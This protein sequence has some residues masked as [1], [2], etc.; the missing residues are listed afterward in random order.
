MRRY[1]VLLLAAAS[2]AAQPNQ[3]RIL[4]AYHSESGN[5][6]KIAMA[7]RDGAAK[8]E[9]VTVTSRKV[10]AVVD[11]DIAKAD[12]IVV[13]TPVHW[14]NLSTET[15]RL[16]DRIG[17]VIS[18]SKSLGDGRAAGAFCTGG[19]VAMG[20][21]LA[22]ISILSAFLTMRFAVIGGVDPYG[23]GTLGPQATTGPD[24]AGISDKE[25]DEARQYGE[26]FAR[27]TARVR[28]ERQ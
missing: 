26:R 7:V 8:V 15:R 23:F 22:R 24:D 5:T 21:D 6:E 9:H 14:S 11:D 13:G 27:F 17:T 3:T 19:G 20:K 18:K 25:L 2:A 10:A 4:I 16:L 1:V 28:V 12:G